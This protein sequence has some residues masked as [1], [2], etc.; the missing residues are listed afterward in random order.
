MGRKALP[1]EQMRTERVTF[2]Y[3]QDE[4]DLL[5][6]WQ[7]MRPEKTLAGIVSPMILSA[8]RRDLG[9]PELKPDS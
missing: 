1:A 7:E 6:R 9:E 2:K 5:R 8:A 3:T 4:R